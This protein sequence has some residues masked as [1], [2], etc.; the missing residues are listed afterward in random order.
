MRRIS[1]IAGFVAAVFLIPVLANAQDITDGSIQGRVL[2][3]DG[4]PMQGAIARIQNLGTNVIDE[5]KTNKNGSY[6]ATGLFQGR[7]KVTLIV[8]GY[9]IM[10]AGEAAGEDIFVGNGQERTVNFDMRKAPA[11]SPTRA[12]PLPANTAG[13]GK[14]DADKKADQEMRAAFTAGMA[15]MK[16]QNYD[17]AVKQLQVA[18]EK[19]PSQSAIFGNLGL[20]LLRTKK[21][22]DAV[23]A[24]RKSIAL[25]PGDAGV[26]GSLSLALGE[27]GKI[28]EAQQEAQE[29][30]KLDPSRAGQSYYNLGAILSE[31]GK[32]KEAVELFK[33]AI[34]VDPKYPSSY[35][36]LGL[37]YFASADTIPSAVSVLEKYLEL[38]PTG[39]NAE[40]AKQL[41]VTAK[42]STPPA[43]KK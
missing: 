5:A 33:K 10:V 38:E 7:Y 20:A 30:A 21:Y 12:A 17:E 39:A 41:I 13:K 29:V 22:D 35:Y 36:Q 23:T 8:D 14:S 25:S 9:I 31:R 27:S 1:S 16:A 43:G 24:F 3:R 18:G 19:D 15:A 40:A 11:A 2:G 37:A 26:H 4:K 28:E 34:E 6:L 32:S 42:A